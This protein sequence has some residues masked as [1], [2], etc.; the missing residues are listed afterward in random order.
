MNFMKT[1]GNISLFTKPFSS[2]VEGYVVIEE[3]LINRLMEKYHP[4]QQ[5]KKA[6]T[7]NLKE[8]LNNI[9]NKS[10]GEDYVN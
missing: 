3:E 2:Y 6:T 1:N 10:N 8:N 7:K 4:S 5:S 9:F